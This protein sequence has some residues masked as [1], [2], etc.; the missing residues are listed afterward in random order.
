MPSEEYLKKIKQKIKEAG[1]KQLKTLD[2]SGESSYGKERLTQIPAEV[3]DLERLEVLNLGHNKLTTVPEAIA[4]MRNLTYLD[5][6]AN[7]LTTVPEAI[8]NL[9]N[10][11][12]LVLGFNQFTT[13]PE[14]ITK[15]QNLT[16]LRLHSNKLTTV[17]DGIANLQKLTKLDLSHNKLTTVPEAIAKLQNLTKLDLSFNQL[18]TVPETITKLQKLTKL[19]LSRNK[20][21]TVP[22][23]IA[24]LQNLTYLDL[25]NNQLTTVPEAIAKLQNLTSLNLYYNQLTTVPETIA[26]LQNL[27]RLDLNFN[28]FTTVPEAIAKMQKL[29]KL[30]LSGN[31][32]TTVPE[33]IAKMQNLTS[34]HL[35][36]NQLTTVPEAIAKIQNLETLWLEK[37]PIET[38]PPE[39]VFD[40]EGK[41]NLEGIRNYFRQLEKE[42]D[43][44]YEAKLLIVGEGGAGKTTLA[45]KIENKDYVLAEDEPTTEGIDVFRWEFPFK[46]N[47]NFRVNIWDF[48]GQEIYHATH[49]FFLTKRSLYTLIADT[50]K[51]DTDFYYWLNVVE[52]LSD[53]SPLLIIKNEKQDRCRQINENQLRGQFANLK[54]TLA[55]NLAT[56][57][58]LPEILKAI[59]LYIS[60]LPHIGV[61]LPKTWVKVRESL[62]NETRNYINLG[63]FLG[64]CEKNGFDRLEDK[65]QLSG[66]LHDLGVCLH[67]Q[68]DPLL[69]KTVI[70][71]PTWGTDAV[72]KVLDN[73][74]VIGSLGKFKREDL[75]KIWNEEKY[76]GM[77]DE[78]LQLMINFKLCYKIR[79]SGGYIAPQLLSANAPEYPWEN[80]QNLIMRYRYEFM[81]KGIL[82]RFIVETHEF[83]AEQKYAWRSGVILQKGEAKAEVIENYGK[84]E[85]VIRVSGQNKK[86]LMTIAAY[87]LDKINDS[88]KRIKLDKLIPCNCSRCKDSIEPHYYR[89][90]KLKKRLRH[91]QFQVQC[92]ESFEDVEVLPLLD[93]FITR[94][95]D[96][97][98]NEDPLHRHADS[99]PKREP[100]PVKEIFISYAWGGE[101]EEIANRLDIAFKEKGITITRDKRDLGFK[102]RIKEFMEQIGRGKCVIVVIS[103][104]YLESMNCMFELMQTAKSGGFYDRIFPLVLAD[105]KIYDPVDRL[106]YV[107]YWE[108]KKKALDNKMKSVSS[109]YLDGFREDIDLYAGIREYLPRLT[110]ILRDMNTLTVEIHSETG[111]KELIEAAAAKLEE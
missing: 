86:E 9:Q 39:V 101:S 31:Q 56:N 73:P 12:S 84:R 68:D 18:T 1:E 25:S 35:S 29:T 100:Q 7:E 69:K 78:L 72:Y 26:N 21:T 36:Y 4:K 92:D 67:F 16:I 44:L 45:K 71:N 13:I 6:R 91:K 94:D 51:E 107:Q 63:E 40:K 15:L 52:M 97:E 42:K 23:A 58:G 95:L 79:N 96:L 2:L 49:Q 22:E 110:D 54:E 43:H 80:R 62:E 102:G 83:I 64:I 87:E 33:A 104:K 66:Y 17:P 89:L 14:T 11:T 81:P 105:A 27:T 90:E 24:N 77:Q 38:P 46:G 75:K 48:G 41:T 55:A 57:R 30:Y 60:N 32:L 53:N 111:F 65:L 85:I 47:K 82:S 3:F 5:L 34:L 108:E 109:E 99:R 103:N 10:L 8:T 50:R 61:E 76:A 74:G 37:N 106:N 98:K 88:F 28:K 70:L 20:F 59:E 19:D 93:D